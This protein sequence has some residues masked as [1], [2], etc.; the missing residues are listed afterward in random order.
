MR[1]LTWYIIVLI[2]WLKKKHFTDRTRLNMDH[3]APLF[4]EIYSQ[5]MDSKVTGWHMAAPIFN[6]FHDDQKYYPE[7]KFFH[8]DG[9][10]YIYKADKNFCPPQYVF[11]HGSYNYCSFY[12]EKT[13]TRKYLELATR[14]LGHFLLDILPSV[15]FGNERKR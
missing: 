4:C 10:E 5:S 14:A 15:V 7:I 3:Q 9:R 8:V 11:D 1:F 6:L 12:S 2:S 13:G